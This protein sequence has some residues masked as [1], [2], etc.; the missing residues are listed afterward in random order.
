MTHRLHS[1]GRTARSPTL[2][3]P[4]R[5]GHASPVTAAADAF[6]TLLGFALFALVA[7]ALAPF[8]PPAAT[9]L[10]LWFVGLPAAFA[11]AVVGVDAATRLRRRLH[12]FACARWR[13]GCE[14]DSADAAV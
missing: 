5:R 4:T 8:V 12:R 3:D 9:L 6:G 10:G 7:S 2:G 13:V 11:G 14:R 1:P